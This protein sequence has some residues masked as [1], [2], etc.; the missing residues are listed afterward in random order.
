MTTMSKFAIGLDEVRSHWIELDIGHIRKEEVFPVYTVVAKGQ[1]RKV[2]MHADSY[3][4]NGMTD[5]RIIISDI[6]D[7]DGIGPVTRTAIRKELVPMVQRWLA[8]DEYKRS[9]EK[10]MAYA[11]AREIRETS[12]TADYRAKDALKHFSKQ[13]TPDGEGRLQKAYDLRMESLQLL[14]GGF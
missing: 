13:V 8:S 6:K 11:I 10:A 9:R 2:R 1:A 7:D 14:D 5:W 3:W 4:A 12:T